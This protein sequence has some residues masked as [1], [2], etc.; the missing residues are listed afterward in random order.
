MQLGGPVQLGPVE[1]GGLVQLV[2]P[3]Q[4]GGLVELDGLDRFWRSR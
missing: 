4:L 1:L 3:V 2:G